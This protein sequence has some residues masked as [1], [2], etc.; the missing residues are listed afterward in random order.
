MF[1]GMFVYLALAQIFVEPSGN[2]MKINSCISAL[3][4]SQ[5][6]QIP[7]P[8]NT[9]TVNRAKSGLQVQQSGIQGQQLGSQG[10]QF[11]S[12]GQ[13]LGSQEQQL[14]SQGQ[15]LGNQRQQLGNQG[16]QMF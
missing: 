6:Q 11:G 1:H 16:K 3:S 2:A 9:Q 14:G 12:Q 7:A 5:Q 13:Q 4:G 10:H 15:Q 8:S